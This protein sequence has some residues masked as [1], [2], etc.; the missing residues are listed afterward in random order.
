M[1]KLV[2]LSAT[3]ILS[4]SIFAQ[5]VS[6]RLDSLLTAYTKQKKFN[7]TIIIG[8]KGNV[9]LEKGYGYKNVKSKEM[10]DKGAI[11]QIGSIT[12]QFT[13]ALILK[14]QEQ[15]KLSVH[16]KIIK[17]FPGY[18]KGD[19]I[20][21][22]NLLT[23]TSGIP[24]YTDDENFMENETSKPHS[25]Q[26][27]IALF[28]DKPLDFS[29]G[30]KWSYSNS[31]YSLLGYIIEDVT[32]KSY[33]K[34]VHEYIFTPLKMTQSG[35][36]FT[37]L[38]SAQKAT[39]YYRITDS[40][41]DVA[42]I[43]DSTVAYSAGSIYSTVGDLYLWHKGLLADKVINA[44]SRAMAFKS[45]MNDYGYGWAIEKWEGFEVVTHGGGIDGFNS[46]IL[47]MTTEDV[48]I[49]SL[50]N[51]P[52]PFLH[53]IALKAL[54]II[55]NKPLTVIHKEA[56]IDPAALDQYVGEYKLSPTF[57]V[58]VSVVDGKLMGKPTGQQESQLFYEKPDQFFL[59][60]VDAQIEFTRDDK[61]VVNGFVLIQNG[62]RI[63]G[64]KVK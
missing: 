13:A 15:K 47:S 10:L 53:E 58:V 40:V 49:A 6:T 54:A 18:P 30:T 64:Q 34:N 19:S 46:D 52:N 60:I 31:A 63:P 57:S 12:K 39:G 43:V 36:D 33:E 44:S 55:Y 25:R 17:Y 28:R 32:R 45:F 4:C 27:M 56:A 11:F 41:A 51:M 5:D 3:V 22:E 38:A 62:R 14:L 16:D 59:K 35:F 23:H 24:N 7:G 37:H 1:K 50:N 29:P 26:Q 42:K 61:K 20:T 9:L 21:I 2:L 48:C 8:Q